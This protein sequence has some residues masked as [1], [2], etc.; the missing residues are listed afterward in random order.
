MLSR[1]IWRN[2]L[3]NR[4]WWKN[5]EITSIKF[6]LWYKLRFW[7]LWLPNNN[8][9]TTIVSFRKKINS[10]LIPIKL[11]INY[12]IISKYFTWN[13]WH[14]TI[15][16]SEYKWR[17]KLRKFEAN[18]IFN[19]AVSIDSVRNVELAVTLILTSISW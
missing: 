4:I 9:Y 6:T 2:Y 3:I 8:K 17:F 1:R 13:N 12:L 15:I 7:L 14:Y 11:K 19:G 5:S 18:N 10:N 16:R